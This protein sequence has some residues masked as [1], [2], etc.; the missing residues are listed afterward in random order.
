MCWFNVTSSLCSVIHQGIVSDQNETINWT[1]IDV[2]E[3][4]PLIQGIASV[5]LALCKDIK[6]AMVS[7]E[8][9]A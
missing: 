5:I 8:Q 9:V 3:A 1:V 2:F 7:F 4:S 6:K